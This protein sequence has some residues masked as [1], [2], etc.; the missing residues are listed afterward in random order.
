MLVTKRLIWHQVRIYLK[1]RW[2]KRRDPVRSHKCT[3]DEACYQFQFE[4]RENNLVFRLDGDKL[5]V[6]DFPVEPD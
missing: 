4:Y 1:A 6:T 5:W 3:N 2:K